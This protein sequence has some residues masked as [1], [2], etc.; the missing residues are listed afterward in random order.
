M[1]QNRK[2]IFCVL[3][4]GL[5][6]LLNTAYGQGIYESKQFGIRMARPENW[7]VATN[8]DLQNNLD[9]LK[10]NEEELRKLL[11]SNKGIITLA[12]Y[13]KYKIDSVSGLIPTVKVT[14]R[15]NPTTN[16]SDFKQVM[17]ESTNR[18]KTVVKN[19]EFV[20]NLKEKNV[21]GFPCLFY[22]CRY[23]LTLANGDNMEVRTRYYMIPKGA[24]FVSISLMDNET[25]ENCLQT[26]DK[27]ISSLQLTK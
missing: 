25:N 18:V 15:A 5:A 17:N 19:F 7:I 8:S 21:S 4:S 16:M 3:L 1:I 11:N 24:Y 20:D 13:Y 2:E 10:F 26:F 23:S 22:S 9:K 27:F 14:V 6:I 12:S